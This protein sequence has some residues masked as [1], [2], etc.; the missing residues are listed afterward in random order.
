ME[1]ID[2]VLHIL[3]LAQAIVW[4]FA[5]RDSGCFWRLPYLQRTCLH[6]P[7]WLHQEID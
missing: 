5:D 6:G 4:V 2:F 1:G 7:V 3:D